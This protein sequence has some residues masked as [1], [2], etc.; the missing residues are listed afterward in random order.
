MF[1]FICPLSEKCGAV[2]SFY[3]GST[4]KS[5]VKRSFRFLPIGLH[6]RGQLKLNKIK[7]I[8]TIIFNKLQSLVNAHD[9]F[10][11]LN[12]NHHI[13][14]FRNLHCSNTNDS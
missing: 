3:V 6:I 7:Y 13:D 4:K 14:N 8:L 12:N 11:S 5:S 10:Q 9:S 1:T 2:G